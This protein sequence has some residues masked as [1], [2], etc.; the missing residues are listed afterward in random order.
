MSDSVKDTSSAHEAEHGL[1]HV[2]PLKVLFGVG[3]ALLVL[4]AVTV[5]VTYVDL[6]RTGN[7]VIAMGI[8][9]VKA[10]L[11]CAY[12][13]H[14]KYDKSFNALVFLSSILFVALFIT[15]TLL[16]KGEYEADIQE[17]YLLEE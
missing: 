3:A 2:M 11:V 7:L 5:W 17:M 14:L 12:F 9:T 6:G 15:I 8:A 16:D 4:T 1:A 10:T 13:M